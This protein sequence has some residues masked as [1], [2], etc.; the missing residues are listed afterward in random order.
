MAGTRIDFMRGRQAPYFSERTISLAEPKKQSYLTGAA[1][2]AGTVALTKVVGMIYK[3]PLFNL[4][5]DEGTGHFNVIYNIY[6]LVLTLSTAGVPVAISRLVSESMAAARPVQA[7]RFYHVGLFAFTLIG[8]AA[9]ALMFIFAQPLADLMNDSQVAAGV[10]CLAPAVFFSCVLAVLRGY[11][12]SHSDMVPTAV[13]QIIEVM[14][15]MVFGLA[16]AWYLRG[17]GYDKPIIAAGAITGVT[18]GL[19][20]DIP[21]IALMSRKSAARTPMTLNMDKPES[22][23]R[24]FW[25]IVSVSIP[26]MLGSSVMNIINL[27]DTAVVR[28]RLASGALLAEEQIDILYGV[29]TKGIT[30]YSLPTAFISPI[31][32]AVVPVLAAARGAKRFDEARATMES[33]MKM[34]NLLAMPAA[35]GLAILAQP[36]FDVLFPGSNEN[37][38]ALLRLLGLASYFV[39]VYIITNGILQAAG[40]EKLALLALPVGGVIKIIISWFLVGDPRINIYGAPIGMVGCYA[41]IT[42]VNIVFIS[43]TSPDKPNYLKITLR[44]LICTL[45]MGAAAWGVYGLMDKF[46]S[47]PLGGGRLA[48]VVC[49]GGAIAVGVVVYAVLIFALRA[50]TKEDIL[51]LPKGEKLAKM[52]KMK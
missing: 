32:I 8:L 7:K 2:L 20:I 35:A 43:M 13:S 50:V 12:Q 38:P 15:K 42:L 40:R 16:I 37:G 52:L 36:I 10:M 28:G 1:I 4:L 26:I 29:Y 33:S 39:C 18:I 21:V 46:V 31:V 47:A 17:Q 27:V 14:C 51:L 25:L 22:C 30:L 48:A 19:G 11:T 41:A 49:L 3:I 5:G 34:T 44:P 6:T 45:L 23:L 24:T 9:M